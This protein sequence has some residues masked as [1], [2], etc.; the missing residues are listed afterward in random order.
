MKYDE[1]S[2]IVTIFNRK[3]LRPRIDKAERLSS[4]DVPDIVYFV[5]PNG[6]E[7]PVD[8]TKDVTVGRI[9]NSADPDV[10]IDLEP[11]D[12]HDLGVSRQHAMLKRI[13][14]NLIL[15]DLASSNGTFVNGHKAEAGDR[16]NI[17]DGDSLTFGRLSLEVRFAKRNRR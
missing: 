9:P 8:V 14:E 12:G 17:M 13:N 15:V 2:K 4:G 1:D 6:L 7:F 3:K 10:S 5:L 11:F 16:Y